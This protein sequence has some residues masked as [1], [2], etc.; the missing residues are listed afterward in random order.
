MSKIN[1]LNQART[2]RGYYQ[3][4]AVL[5]LPSPSLRPL[6]PSSYYG[7]SMAE[8]WN[9]VAGDHTVYD[10][11]FATGAVGRRLA[12][13]RQ[14]GFPV[15]HSVLQTFDISLCQIASDGAGVESTDGY[16]QAVAEKS[17]SLIRGNS[18]SCE[19]IERIIAKYPDFAPDEKARGLL[20]LKGA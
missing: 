8:A 17:I 6:E 15:G 19:H 20:A 3:D 16:R 18:S 5:N 11:V 7:G 4:E 9:V 10:I 12:T 14:S 1:I 2:W 13:D